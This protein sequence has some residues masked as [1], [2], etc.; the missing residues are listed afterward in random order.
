MK[1][2]T[3][4]LLTT[5]LSL[6]SGLAILIFFDEGTLFLAT[7]L[8]SIIAVKLI[9]KKMLQ[10]TSRTLDSFSIHNF[11]G[12]WFALSIAPAL[13]V[14]PEMI[15]SFSNGFLIQALLSYGFFLFFHQIKPSIIG[16]IYTS[17]KGGVSL[18]AS[19]IIAGATAGIASSAL[20]QTYLSLNISL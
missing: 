9:N 20:W 10:D 14:Q 1:F 3:T 4:L 2:S 5:L 13:S 15:F 11:A 6:I 7:L 18:I 16:K 12:L 8:V 17:N 19:D